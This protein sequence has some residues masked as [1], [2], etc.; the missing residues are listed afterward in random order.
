MDAFTPLQLVRSFGETDAVAAQ[1][2]NRHVQRA[3][4]FSIRGVKIHF[5]KRCSG[6]DLKSGVLELQEEKTGETHSVAADVVIGCDGS[7]SAIRG[8]M[9]KRSRFNFSQQYLDYGYKELTIPAAPGGK[10]AL[11]TNALHIWPRGNYMLIA[12]PNVDG[13]FACILFLPFEGKDSFEQLPTRAAVLEFFQLQ[14]PDLP[15]VSKP[16]SI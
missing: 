8:E 2:V 3:E 13:T 12:L 7:A 11:E 9:L 1:I 5:Q 4:N 6:I 15:G 10:H 14:F 16:S